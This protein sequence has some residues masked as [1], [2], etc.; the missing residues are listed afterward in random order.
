MGEC[1]SLCERE[2]HNFQDEET[3]DSKGAI[4]PKRTKKNKTR[5]PQAVISSDDEDEDIPIAKHIS[6]TIDQDPI[7]SINLM[8]NMEKESDEIIEKIKKAKKNWEYLVDKLI[9][10]RINIL[11][12]IVKKGKIENKSNSDSEEDEKIEDII[13]EKNF[14]KSDDKNNRIEQENNISDEEKNEN[15]K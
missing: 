13:K 9:Q 10:Q 5:I 1:L 11:R 15:I 3:H 8:N 4:T 14:Y 2:E 12:E 7:K 6:N